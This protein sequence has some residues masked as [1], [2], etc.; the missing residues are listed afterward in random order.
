MLDQKIELRERRDFGQVLNASFFF[1]RQQFKPLGRQLLFIVGPFALVGS[2]LPGMGMYAMREKVNAMNAL[3]FGFTS[4]T[5]NFFSFLIAFTLIICIV[6]HYLLQYEE[7]YPE[8]ISPSALWK[9]VRRDFFRV[10]GTLVGGFVLA[11]LVYTIT[12]GLVI[13]IGAGLGIG[14]ASGIGWIGGVIAS[15]LVVFFIFALLP[16][17]SAILWMLFIIRMQERLGFFDAIGRFINLQRGQWWHT[18]T[19][20]LVCLIMQLSAMGI[21]IV[22]YMIWVIPSYTMGVQEQS[23]ISTTIGILIFR[24]LFTLLWVFSLGINLI[25]TAYQY[26]SLV[27][28]KESI[29]LLED[30]ENMGKTPQDIGKPQPNEEEQY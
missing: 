28:K 27:E 26:F 22:P 25:T 19:L 17:L 18:F 23:I 16:I 3:N 24:V 11:S 21:L 9:G 12:A 2:I 5:V 13:G 20:Q 4:F 14:I 1:I 7:T 6:N 10:L 30:I 8:K 15:I 29:G